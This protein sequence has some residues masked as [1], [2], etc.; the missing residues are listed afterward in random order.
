[1]FRVRI[2]NINCYVIV[3]EEILFPEGI[4]ATRTLIL[5]CNVIV[6][7]EILF[8]EGILATRTLILFCNVIPAKLF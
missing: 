3:K 7:E 2:Y 1:M 4:L 5:F 6:K 8:P